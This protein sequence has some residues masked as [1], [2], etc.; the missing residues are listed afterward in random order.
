MYVGGTLLLAGRSS[1]RFLW[2]QSPLTLPFGLPFFDQELK[3]SDKSKDA[4]GNVARMNQ[5]GAWIK[6]GIKVALN[7]LCCF[8]LFPVVWSWPSLEKISTKHVFLF[9]SIRDLGSFHGTE[10]VP[11]NTRMAALHLTKNYHHLQCKHRGPSDRDPPKSN[12][13]WKSGGRKGQRRK[14]PRKPKPWPVM[15]WDKC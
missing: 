13:Q 2:S 14:S 3:A 12:S 5:N 8:Q 4:K 1:M 11:Q 7:M 15:T 6:I 9:F 10:W